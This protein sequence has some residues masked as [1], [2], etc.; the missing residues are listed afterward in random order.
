VPRRLLGED[1]CHSTQ[2]VGQ[3]SRAQTPLHPA[4]PE[5]Y[6][7]ATCGGVRLRRGAERE[8]AVRCDELER[9]VG[10]HHGDAITSRR[11]G[12]R[13]ER[14]PGKDGNANAFW[15]RGFVLVLG[16]A[17]AIRTPDHDAGAR[18]GRKPSAS[19]VA[20]R[21][22]LSRYPSSFEAEPGPSSSTPTN[23]ASSKPH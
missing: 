3:H 6:P 19:D 17:G 13:A 5:M 10:A 2:E 21:R 9:R 15:Q 18:Q 20:A 7:A 16:C 23:H 4:G 12:S 22:G 14:R 11:A 8:H 1:R